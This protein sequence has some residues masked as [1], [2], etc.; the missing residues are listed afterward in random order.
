M[1]EMLCSKQYLTDAN[2]TKETELSI[3]QLL[4]ATGFGQKVLPRRMIT[5]VEDASR[6]WKR[7]R[8]VPM[9]AYQHQSH[10]RPRSSVILKLRY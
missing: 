7:H 10:R 6:T 5:I 9:P 4:A 8:V 2:C 3:I 1:F